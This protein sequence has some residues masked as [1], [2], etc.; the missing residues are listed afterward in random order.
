M[1]QATDLVVRGA[2]WH[3]TVGNKM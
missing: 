1:T 2:M 3:W